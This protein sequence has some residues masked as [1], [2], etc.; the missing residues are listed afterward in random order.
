MLY[1]LLRLLARV[2]LNL[3]FRRIEVTGQSQ[4][5]AQGPVLFV[6]NHTNALVDPLFL[7]ISLRRRVTM[8]AKNV[9]GNNRLSSALMAS[10]GVVTFHRREDVGKGADRKQNLRSLERCREILR[11][12]GAICIFPEGISHSDPHLR[13]FRTGAARIALDYVHEDANP[14]GLVIVPV[15][16]LYTAKDQ[17]RSNVWLRYGQAID[18]ARWL[19]EHPQSDGAHA[20]TADVFKQIEELTVNF[21][22]RREALIL[23]WGAAILASGG[24]APAPLGWQE[25]PLEK[26]FQLLKR[27]QAGYRSIVETRPGEVEALS[28]RVRYYRSELTRLGIEPHEVYLPIHFGKAAFFLVREMELLTIGAPLALAGAIN[29]CVPYYIVK[30]IARKLSRDKDHWATNV[31]YPSFV[32]FPLCYAMQI[33]AAWWWLP[34]FWAWLYTITL[35]YTGYVALLYGDRARSTWQRLRAFLYFVGNRSRQEE[36]AREGRDIIA[37]IRALGEKVPIG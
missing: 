31:V 21:E 9:L 6:A 8:T 15:G 27:L 22:T 28:T 37:G 20:L 3:F 11:R 32:V 35:P 7:I 5:P 2:M 26:D 16:L 34:A 36:L 19:E 4:V 30:F 1:L 23:S 14:G 33:G 25:R 13:P 18:V 24:G 12:D 17:F 10:L 29:H